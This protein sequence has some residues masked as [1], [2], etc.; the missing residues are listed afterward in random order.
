MLLITLYHRWKDH[1]KDQP[2]M[3]RPIIKG[4]VNQFFSILKT[5]Y[6]QLKAS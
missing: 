5:D 4:A 2:K 1:R 6:I 3:E